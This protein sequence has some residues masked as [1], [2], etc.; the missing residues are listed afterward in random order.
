MNCLHKSLGLFFAIITFSLY[1]LALTSCTTQETTPKGP[2]IYLNNS[3]DVLNTSIVLNKSDFVI[4]LP[5]DDTT[6][7]LLIN[8]ANAADMNITDITDIINQSINASKNEPEQKTEQETLELSSQRA[9]EVEFYFLLKN[10]SYFRHMLKEHQEKT[11]NL[12]GTLVT[13]QPVF[14]SEDS[15]IFK[16]NNFTT[17]ALKEEDWASEPDFE[18]FVKD[19]YYRP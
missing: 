12:S 15:V 3:Q 11:Y 6:D 7:A 4:I 9:S 10:V 8:S 18:I 16:I 2:P 1:L 17:K 13:I 14:I 5:S 19:I